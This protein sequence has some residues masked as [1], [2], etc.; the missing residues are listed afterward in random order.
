MTIASLRAREILDSRGNPTVA[1]TAILSDGTTAQA[2]VP[3]GASTGKYEALEL[4]D[5]DPARYR[6][7]GVLRAAANVERV[8]EPAVRGMDPADQAALDRRM[9]ELDGTTDKSRLGANAIL[10][11]SCA[12]ARAAAAA[13]RVPLWEHLKG[14]RK[15]SMP[16]LTVNI[17]SGGLHAGYN[18]E[19]QDFMAVP[20]DWPATPINCRRLWR[21][22][23]PRGRPSPAAATC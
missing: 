13:R 7:K 20:V 6:G 3:S 18:F 15:A 23:A 16:L 14:G 11:V 1:V 2:K 12:V 19:F 22:I 9:I 21:C 5:G 10:G 4:R 8:I 17:L